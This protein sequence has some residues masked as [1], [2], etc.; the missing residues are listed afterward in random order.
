MQAIPDFLA[1]F[2]RF[3]VSDMDGIVGRVVAWK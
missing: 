3:F 2:E 1:L